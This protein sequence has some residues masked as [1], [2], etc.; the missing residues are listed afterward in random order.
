MKPAEKFTPH[1][2]RA[3]VITDLL[4]HGAELRHVQALAGHADPR[5]TQLYH[6][7]D[8]TVKQNLVERIS[9]KPQTPSKPGPS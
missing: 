3:S 7:G 2:F 6:H 8:N 4:E 9:F 5:T 1:S